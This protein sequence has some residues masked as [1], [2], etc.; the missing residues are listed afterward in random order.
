MNSM[1]I[2]IVPLNCQKKRAYTPETLMTANS[3]IEFHFTVQILEQ[4]TLC[5]MEQSSIQNYTQHYYDFY[6]YFT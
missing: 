1:E 6:E 4:Y 3:S 5:A 2:S